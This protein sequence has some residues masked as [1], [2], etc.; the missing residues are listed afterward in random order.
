MRTITKEEI[1]LNKK[2]IFEITVAGMKQ[3][4]EFLVEEE[5]TPLGKMNFLVSKRALP[6]N[7]LMRI[8]EENQMPVKCSG[9][10]LFPKGKGP[11]DFVV[12]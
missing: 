8:A 11:K 9:Q 3:K 5:Q 2:A 6:L 1:L 10:K 7:E 12:Q 4:H